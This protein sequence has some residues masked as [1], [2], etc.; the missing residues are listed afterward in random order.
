L[1]GVV[2][3]YFALKSN[4]PLALKLFFVT[5]FLGSFTTFSSFALDA[6]LLIERG[7]VF[8][9]FLYVGSSVFLGLAGYFAAIYLVRVFA[10]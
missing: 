1:I 5:G 2:V 6:G 10:R 3:E 9:T 7:E 4:L 8:K